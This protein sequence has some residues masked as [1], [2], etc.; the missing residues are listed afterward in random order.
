MLH[1]RSWIENRKPMFLIAAAATAAVGAGVLFGVG[2]LSAAEEPTGHAARVAIDDAGLRVAPEPA[3]TFR[4]QGCDPVVAGEVPR[5]AP[6]AV[7]IPDQGLL[8]STVPS[9]DLVLP[10]AP[11][12]IFYTESAAVGSDAGNTVVAGHVDYA[13]G[14]L[15]PWG[16]LHQVQQCAVVYAA[17]QEGEVTTYQVTDLYTVP[18][19]ELEAAGVF[20]TDGEAHLVLVTCSGPSVEDA[21]PQFAFGYENNLVVEATEVVA[22]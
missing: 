20:A 9:A 22:A 1:H 4:A 17:D 13:D 3:Q 12:G 18:Q 10:E 14:E 8:L 15:S 19:D 11:E 2:D 16:H 6:G 21:G 7:E 5:L